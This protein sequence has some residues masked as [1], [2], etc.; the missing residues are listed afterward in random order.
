MKFSKWRYL[1]VVCVFSLC[2]SLLNAAVV[3]G[4][5]RQ[6]HPISLTFDGPN[7]CEDDAINPFTGYAMYVTFTHGTETY[8]VPGYFATD[9]NASESGATCGNKWRVH[10][11]PP[12]PGG[13]N[14][15]AEMYQ[16][17][18]VVTGSGSGTQVFF[19]G[20]SGTLTITPSNK[21][22]KDFRA[23]GRLVY[24]GERYL[25]F[26]GSNTYYVASGA[27]SPENFLAYQDFD[28]TFNNGGPDYI[29]AY[30]THIPDWNASDPVWHGNA[31]KG[32]IGAVNYLSSVGVTS[33]YMLMFNVNGDGDDVWPF[34]DAYHF[35]RMDVSKLAQW[36]IVFEH[37]DRKGMV[38]HLLFQEQENDQLMNGGALGAS[39]RVYYREMVARFGHLNGLVWNLGEENTNT[40]EQR[41]DHASYLRE[42]D[43]YHHPILAHTYPWQ[44][45]LVYE[46]LLGFDDFEG[47]ALQV[48]DGDDAE[49]DTE[50]WLQRSGAAGR[51]WVCFLSE[52]GPASDG[53]LPDSEDPEHNSVRKEYLWPHL[54]NGGSGPE[55]YFGN[56]YE[57]TDIN[58]EDFRSRENM[59]I[60]SAVAKA[61]FDKIPV[62]RL[63]PDHDRLNRS[64][65]YCMT[66]ESKFH[67]VYI[68]DG[69]PVQ[70]QLDVAGTWTLGFYDPRLGGPIQNVRTFS[71]TAPG[72]YLIDGLPDSQDW[73]VGLI[74][75]GVALKDVNLEFEEEAPTE[76]PSS[77]Q[78]FPNPSSDDIWLEWPGKD[79]TIPSLVR[80]VNT[81]GSVVYEETTP[82]STLN[83]DIADW[84]EGQYFYQILHGGAPAFAGSFSCINK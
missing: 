31:G 19:H 14:W 38:K 2:G 34:T 52:I 66:L 56:A 37:M 4:E 60:Q 36:L 41:R 7:V 12:S 29:K 70:I 51:Q 28:G 21:G 54:M 32:I 50:E 76:Q 27:G 1:L 5:L 65:T 69:L 44:K 61:L 57:H 26:A 68:P 84:A 30:A 15:T 24:A 42:L 39:R 83:V 25:L 6:W 64:G 74:R 59:F 13:W 78:A 23:Q 22:G 43:A 71:I 53:V 8:R 77:G 62:V 47:A 67:L 63:L 80:I 17:S 45:E 46:P 55:W 16:G 9:G 82:N 33:Q 49:D 81:S 48:S 18:D 40:E 73:V 3:G 35:Y 75:R 79:I 11:S 10:F 58:C 20:N 72:P